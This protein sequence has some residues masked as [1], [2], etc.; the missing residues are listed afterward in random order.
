MTNTQSLKT[1][2]QSRVQPAHTQ[3]IASQVHNLGEGLTCPA[4]AGNIQN[5]VY[6]RLVTQN[7]L[8][9]RDSACS[10]Y[11]I[12]AAKFMQYETNQRPV[13]PI[14]AAGL[15]GASDMMGVSRETIPSNLYNTGFHDFVRQYPTPN[16][17]PWQGPPPTRQ[18]YHKRIPV[19]DFGMDGTAIR[20]NL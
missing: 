10:H 16:N 11:A 15:R 5:D 17:A 8:D 13:L 6:G 4:G 18:S 12:T 19:Y 1:V 9:L 14:C 7:T 2:L 3:R 20:L